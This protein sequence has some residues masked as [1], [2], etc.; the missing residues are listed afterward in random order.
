MGK[1]SG[2]K[3]LPFAYFMSTF[4]ELI[5]DCK[6]L[7][8][9]HKNQ[10]ECCVFYF[11]FRDMIFGNRQTDFFCSAFPINLLTLVQE[12]FTYMEV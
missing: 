4:L 12:A 1:F 9:A 3:C 10:N 11:L 8:A 5:L 2:T 6:I 7:Y